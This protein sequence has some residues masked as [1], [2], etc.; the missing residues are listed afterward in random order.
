[1]QAR[2]SVVGPSWLRS[3]IISH[4]KTRCIKTGSGTA[5]AFFTRGLKVFY[6]Q[7]GTDFL[8]FGLMKRVQFH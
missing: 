7:S 8:N 5:R 1:M 4:I 2:S 3:N 6:K